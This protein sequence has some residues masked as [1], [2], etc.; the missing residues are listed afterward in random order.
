MLKFYAGDVGIRGVLQVWLRLQRLP[1]DAVQDALAVIFPR[2]LPVLDP[3]LV[4]FLEQ[5]Q[6]EGGF[7]IGLQVSKFPGA[8]PL[9]IDRNDCPK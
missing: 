2:R 5:R 8:P 6:R 7:A 4:G 9:N 3:D 1:G